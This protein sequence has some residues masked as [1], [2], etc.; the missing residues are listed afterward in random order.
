MGLNI[1]HSLDYSLGVNRTWQIVASFA[2][3]FAPL[4]STGAN[5]AVSFAWVL[6]HGQPSADAARDK[7][8][9]A[10]TQEAEYPCF[11]SPTLPYGRI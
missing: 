4:L 7:V 3:V 11:R 10:D 8:T 9:F 1:S 5:F 2:V 6:E